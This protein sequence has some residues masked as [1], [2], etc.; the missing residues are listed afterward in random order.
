MT[1]TSFLY[2]AARCSADCRA[3]SRGHATRRLR[4]RLVGRALGRLGFWRRLWR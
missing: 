2:H 4:N 3:I 1:L